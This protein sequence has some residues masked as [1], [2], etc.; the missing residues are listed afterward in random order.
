VQIAFTGTTSSAATIVINA[1]AATSIAASQNQQWTSSAFVQIVQTD[2][3]VSV[4]SA[5]QGWG[6]TERGSGG[7]FLADRVTPITTNVGSFFRRFQ[8]ATLN[9]PAVNFVTPRFV[10]NTISV[11]TTINFAVR[12]GAHTLNQG[13][14]TSPIAT[15]WSSAVTRAADVLTLS[16]AMGASGTLVAIVNENIETAFGRYIQLD[17]GV[18]ANRLV[19]AR[20]NA[21]GTVAFGSAGT[22]SGSVSIAG[23]IGRK[24]VAAA[25]GPSDLAISV[26]GSAVTTSATHTAP[27][28]LTTVRIG[29]AVS[30]ASN[31]N[32]FVER[33]ILF[34]TRVNNATLQSYAT[35]ST[36]GG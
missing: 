16:Q 32:G 5:G 6:L 15:S 1:A 19:L 14:L 26:N 31:L 24:A 35:L 7:I 3:N 9:D 21:N 8:T 20:G 29:G 33:V 17:T 36:W 27:T 23:A 34:P 11:G 4:G 18:D 28:G 13:G 30:G 22:G 12:I 10:T 2:P 25:Y